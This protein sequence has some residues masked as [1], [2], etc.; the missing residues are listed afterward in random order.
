MVVDDPA[1]GTPTVPM[2]EALSPSEAEFY[3]REENVVK[4]DDFSMT[5]FK[6]LESHYGFVGGTLT[7]Y[8]NY[9]LSADVDPTLWDWRLASGVRAVAGFSCVGEK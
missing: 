7:E 9:Y 6:Q 3:A 4:T 1:P 2:L 8:V 5:I